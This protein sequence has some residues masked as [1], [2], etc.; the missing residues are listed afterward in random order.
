ME[1]IVHGQS[2]KG[3]LHGSRRGLP[4]SRKLWLR[5]Y[6]GNRRTTSDRKSIAALSSWQWLIIRYFWHEPWWRWLS[7]SS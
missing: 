4:T 6:G 2:G 5:Q 3:L 7:E 1:M